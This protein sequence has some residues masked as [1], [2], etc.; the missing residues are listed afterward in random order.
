MISGQFRRYW[1]T[2]PFHS[3]ALCLADGRAIRV[4]H[5]KTVAMSPSG[6]TVSVMDGDSDAFETVDLLLVTSLKPLNGR[7][8]K[9][10]R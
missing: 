9:S 5:P 3:F 8:K 2:K 4:L 6:R 7:W 1:T 10:G